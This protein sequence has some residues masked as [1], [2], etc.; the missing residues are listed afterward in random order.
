MRKTLLTLLAM[1][2]LSGACYAKK[3]SPLDAPFPRI[4]KGAKLCLSSIAPGDPFYAQCRACERS[5]K[6]CSG[7]LR[8]RIRHSPYPVSIGGSTRPDDPCYEKYSGCDLS[9]PST[10]K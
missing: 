6:K 7:D 10:K 1:T 8:D 4:K 2:M 9:K 3:A 5:A